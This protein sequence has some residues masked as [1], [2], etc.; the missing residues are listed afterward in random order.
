M[1]VGPW[2]MPIAAIG[3]AAVIGSTWVSIYR[4]NNPKEP[5]S[6][7]NSMEARLGRLEGDVAHL[8]ADQKRMDQENRDTRARYE[9]TVASIFA[10]IDDLR[11]EI[12]EIF[13]RKE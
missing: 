2:E 9:S 13:K 8:A 6:Q 7:E 1:N 3:V 12:I 10:A 11:K 4:H 5:T